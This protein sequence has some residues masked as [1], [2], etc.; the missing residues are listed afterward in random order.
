MPFN[1]YYK[2]PNINICNKIDG[3]TCRLGNIRHQRLLYSVIFASE[4][5]LIVEL[6]SVETSFSP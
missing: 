3:E 4:L 1:K 2:Y 5:L 6:F